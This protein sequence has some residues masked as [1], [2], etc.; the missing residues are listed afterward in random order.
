MYKRL[1]RNRGLQPV[2][3]IVLPQSWK[4][5]ILEELHDDILS[6]HLG[7]DRTFER[8]H[9]HYYWPSYFVDAKNWCESCEECHS[10]KGSR[11]KNKTPLI[12][13]PV[14]GKPFEEIAIDFLEIKPQG[15]RVEGYPMKDIKADKAARLLLNEWVARFG[16]PV[17][18][19]SDQ[20]SQFESEL[21]KE[22]CK[23]LETKKKGTSLYHPQSDGMVECCNCTFLD[24]LSIYASN[25]RD[26]D[27]K[28]PL[29]LFAYRTSLHSSTNFSPFR[30]TFRREAHA[31]QDLM[32]GPPPGEKLS[33]KE[34]V[35]DLQTELRRVFGL[36]REHISSAQR[37]QKAS[38]DRDLKAKYMQYEPGTR[39]MLFDPT[40]RGKF[41][42]PNNPWK[43]PFRVIERTGPVMYKIEIGNGEK[44]HVNYDRL[45]GCTE[46]FASLR[47]KKYVFCQQDSNRNNK[48]QVSSKKKCLTM[49]MIS[50]ICQDQC[51]MQNRAQNRCL[52]RAQWPIQSRTF[53]IPTSF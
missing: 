15:N 12:S 49:R 46:R 53:V 28:L 5:L 8:V 48:C 1:L 31:P 4:Q 7:T 29:L 52:F 38:Y 22:M 19:N 51:Q 6:S 20:G 39:V 10:R 23:I 37:C 45:K 35:V 14:Q 32:F 42:K 13:I 40:A 25:E 17:S 26:W 43:G 33:R 16:C 30:L 47:N 24:M 3:Q 2:L 34:W 50:R 41:G 21:F 9:L 36:C 44:M 18:V 11:S 27:L